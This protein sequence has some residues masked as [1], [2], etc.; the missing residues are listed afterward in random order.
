MSE[1]Y[2]KFTIF[3]I[4]GILI[5]LAIFFAP[6]S[7]H[8][9]LNKAGKP[10][11]GVFGVNL[12]YYSGPNMGNYIDYLNDY[13]GDL[14]SSNKIDDFA[15][16]LALTLWFK[17][18]FSSHFAYGFF[19]TMGGFATDQVFKYQ[20][21]QE[22]QSFQA[23]EEYRLKTAQIGFDLTYSPVNTQKSRLF[24]YISAG[25][26]LSS[27]TMEVFYSNYTDPGLDLLRS[28]GYRENDINIGY[29]FAA[30]LIYPVSDRFA[31]SFNT[32]FVDSRLNFDAN[33]DEGSDIDM[34]N[35]QWFTGIGV[36]Y[37]YR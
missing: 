22:T 11:P 15:G 13:Y 23:Y 26:L 20:N 6:S 34:T 33:F 31:I 21:E 36:S 28:L 8:A 5:F 14:G 16:R 25:G 32:E 12:G 24:P 19:L 9:E 3:G 27:G 18:F 30:G 4:G 1:K 35:R 2:Y 10:A 17:S 7:L 29:R 37:F